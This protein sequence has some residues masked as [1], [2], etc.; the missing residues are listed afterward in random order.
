[1]C[2][3]LKNRL[4][5]SIE[6]EIH[7]F[8]VSNMNNVLGVRTLLKNN[9]QYKN[10]MDKSSAAINGGNF[11]HSIIQVAI[12]KRAHRRTSTNYGFP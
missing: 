12:I 10:V 8:F 7:F 6:R 9:A 11:F 1:M 3:D 2:V 5:L 4:Y